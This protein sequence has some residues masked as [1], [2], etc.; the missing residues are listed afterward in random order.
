MTSPPARRFTA[1]DFER[2]SLDD[3]LEAMHAQAAHDL[4]ALETATKLLK[5]VACKHDGK[6]CAGGNDYILCN[7]C[8]LMWDYRR[9]N[10][11]GILVVLREMTA[12]KLAELE[13]L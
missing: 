8:G 4:T 11:V 2:A 7:A 12:M 9:G 1:K 13:G 6:D 3:D 5:M 10:E